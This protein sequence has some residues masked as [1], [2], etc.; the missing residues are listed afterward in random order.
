MPGSLFTAQYP[1]HPIELCT[2]LG[3]CKW[4]IYRRKL[5]FILGCIDFWNRVACPPLVIFQISRSS[6]PICFIGRWIS[7]CLPPMDLWYST[8]MSSPIILV[9]ANICFYFNTF[10][11]CALHLVLTVDSKVN[12]NKWFWFLEDG[13]RQGASGPLNFFRC[14]SLRVHTQLLSFGFPTWWFQW[15]NSQEECKSNRCTRH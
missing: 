11:S 8:F 4:L 12:R 7:A 1:P 15:G 13:R 3:L 14:F 2:L 6:A 10:L 5:V 9:G